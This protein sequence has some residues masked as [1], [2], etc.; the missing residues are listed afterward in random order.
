MIFF[1]SLS[2][3]E[4]VELGLRALQLFRLVRRLSSLY[5]QLYSLLSTLV[6]LSLARSQ[7]RSPS[8]L[9]FSS[10]RSHL[11]SS[12]SLLSH[13]PRRFGALNIAHQR[14]DR[15][16]LPAATTDDGRHSPCHCFAPLLR[17]RT[18]HL[19]IFQSLMAR[20]TTFFYSLAQKKQTRK[21]VAKELF[22][23]KNRRF[24]RNLLFRRRRRRPSSFLPLP[25]PKPHPPTTH[26]HKMSFRRRLKHKRPPAGWDKIE[27]TIEDFEAQMRDVVAEGHEGERRAALSWKVHRVH[28]EK[29][30]FIFDLVYVRKVMSRELVSGEFFCFS[31]LSCVERKKRGVERER[32]R[33]KENAHFDNKNS[34]KT[35]PSPSPSPIS[36]I[37]TTGSSGRK[38]PTA[39]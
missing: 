1:A 29:N 13:A 11:S 22:T 17:T 15:P 25:P 26:H 2:P 3:E 39:P 9:L 28:W 36:I 6:S 37:S 8:F 38:S 7:V 10:Q 5:S 4:K 12:L 34:L 33:E 24:V 21:Q 23:K 30:R 19:Q 31:V 27:D 18:S 14:V 35:S 20:A 32:E 16:L